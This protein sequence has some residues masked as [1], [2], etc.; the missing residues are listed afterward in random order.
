MVA[1]EKSSD[2][3]SIKRP[4]IAALTLGFAAFFLLS[5]YECARS[6]SVSLYIEAYGAD[7]LP[8]VLVLGPIG[9][10][11]LLYGYG[12][13]LSRYGAERTLLFTSLISGLGILVCYLAIISG[14]K[15]AVGGI[16]VLREAYIVL[17]IEQYWSFINSTLKSDQAKRVNG[18]ICGIAS[19]GAIG[20][21]LFVG[22]AGSWLSTEHLLLF[23]AFSLLPAAFLSLLAYKLG[24]EPMPSSLDEQKGQGVLALNL[25]RRNRNVLYI[26]MLVTLTQVIATVLELRFNG[27]LETAIPVMDTRT[28]YLGNF[29]AALNGVAFIFEFVFTPIMLRFF[30][31]RHVHFAIPLVHL[32]TCI[33]LFFH[34][35]LLAGA[36]AYLLFK[37]L[38]YSVFRAGK[39][40]LYIPLPFDARFRAK[41]LIDAFIYRASKGAT[42]GLIAS[43]TLLFGRLPGAIYPSIAIVSA[44]VW[45]YLVHHL[46]R[47]RNEVK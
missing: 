39:E 11:V 3:R 18:P 35:S 2:G 28:A 30:S 8:V 5:G 15:L 47:N 33:I 24:G 21:A 22:Q 26:A 45:L 32:T 7:L 46:T 17:L 43:A 41:E 12:W 23:A 34:P 14:N 19:I 13:L 20:G 4:V 27:M 37:A 42:S 25:F 36:G 9:T 40:I 16:Y 31:L 10:L 38:D 6:A 29:Y 1:A 44:T